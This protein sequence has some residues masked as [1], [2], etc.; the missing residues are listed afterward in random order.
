MVTLI[1]VKIYPD[2]G[3]FTDSSK[4]LPKHVLTYKTMVIRGADQRLIS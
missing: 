4:L 3:M 1:W 2:D